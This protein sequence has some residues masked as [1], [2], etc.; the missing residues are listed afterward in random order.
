MFGIK[1]NRFGKSSHF[2]R[3]PI[4]TNFELA[5]MPSEVKRPEH[6]ADLRRLKILYFLILGMMVVCVGRLWFLQVVNSANYVQK[7]DNQNKHR[8]RYMAPR[9]EIKDSKGRLLAA[10][11]FQFFISVDKDEIRKNPQTLPLL[12]EILKVPIDSLIEKIKSSRGVEPVRV[13]DNVDMNLQTRIEEQKLDLAG[14]FITQDPVRYYIDGRITAHIL[15]YTHQIRDDQIQRIHKQNLTLS[16][17]KRYY[18]SDSVGDTGLEESYETYLRGQDGGPNVVIDAKKRMV[19][20]LD[21]TPT[22]PGNSLKLNIDLDLQKATYD[23]LQDPLR[24]G[25]PGSAI[26]LDPNTGAVLAFVSTPSF[27]PNDY[28]GDF[29]T[30]IAADK[31]FKSEGKRRPPSPFLNRASGSAYMPGSTFKLVTAA[32]GLE[33]GKI[34]PYSSLYCGGGLEVGNRYFNC[35]LHSGHGSIALEEAIGRS[36]DVYFYRVGEMVHLDNLSNWAKRF[37]LSSKTGIDLPSDKRGNIP[38]PEWLIEKHK[39]WH[40]G[41]LVN[42]A[43][44]QGDVQVSPLQLVS[45]VSALANGGTLWKPQLV[46]EIVDSSNRT[47]MKIKP[48]AKGKLGLQEKNRLAIL[49]GMRR[50]V[51]SGGT[52]GRLAIPG[53]EFAGKTGTAQRGNGTN[54][55]VFVCYAPVDHPKI[56]IAVLVE[57]TRQ[58]GADIAGPV[59]RNMLMNYFHKK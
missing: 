16:D 33:T 11:K 38:S 5:K 12:A 9:G 37:G 48:E 31:K 28:R 8:I 18:D 54:N 58:N 23:A 29:N 52:A 14:V 35:D 22:I 43:I 7:S 47:V 55:G 4:G 10:N 30:F 41:N 34:T 6:V 26:A 20:K 2:G 32:A 1:R 36:C 15:G 40:P 59:A 42:M 19:T 56:A 24:D 39:E 53:L 27:D 17:R 44:G 50:V 57:G 3:L 45:Y 21:E 49:R 25:L 13:A 51:E 46:S